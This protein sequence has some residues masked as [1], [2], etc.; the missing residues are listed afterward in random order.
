M[1]ATGVPALD[2]LLVWGGAVT[3]LAGA[4]TVAWRVVRGG[5]RLGHRVD[6]FIDDWYGEP[7]RP[8]IPA[9]PGVLE[10]VGAI[11]DRLGR[12]EHE[13]YPNSGGSLRDAV[14]QANARLSRLCLDLEERPPSEPLDETDPPPPAAAQ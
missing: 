2:T 7:S 6:H 3:I 12:V 1:A 9:R 4:G 10:R 14:D 5:I 8:G 13:L 11:E